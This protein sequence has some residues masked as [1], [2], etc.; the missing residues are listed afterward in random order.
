MGDL[1]KIITH[2]P[3]LNTRPHNLGQECIPVGCVPPAHW[4]NFIVSAQGGVHAPTMHTPSSMHAPTAMH[5]PCHVCTPAMHV[6]LPCMPPAMDALAM[7]APCHGCPP[8]C[9]PH[10]THTHPCHACPT[11]HAPPPCMHTPCHAY[12]RHTHTHPLWTE[13]YL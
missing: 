1:A 7:H 13:R 4:P 10:H 11:M 6:P 2:F 8:P 9:T 5:S 12:P 3:G